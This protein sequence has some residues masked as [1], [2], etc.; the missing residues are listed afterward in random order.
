MWQKFLYFAFFRKLLAIHC[1][2]TVLP[3]LYNELN[4]KFFILKIE[5]VILLKSQS[6]ILCTSVLLTSPLKKLIICLLYIYIW[7]DMIWYGM[8]WYD[9][10]YVIILYNLRYF[11]LLPGKRKKTKVS[12]D[13][14]SWEMFSKQLNR[15]SSRITGEKVSLCLGFTR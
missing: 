4:C 7:Y 12:A 3:C 11:R 1:W 14:F 9:M 2:Y 6:L 13:R 15:H 10:I 8:I 5:Y